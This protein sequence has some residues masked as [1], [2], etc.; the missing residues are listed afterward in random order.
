MNVT[1]PTSGLAG[2]YRP[3]VARA[4]TPATP[5]R[6]A[7]EPTAAADV[8][9]GSDPALWAILTTEERAFFQKQ[10]TMG[11]LSYSPSSRPAAST[12]GPPLGQ[13]ID[14]TA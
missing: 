1:G 4:A 9:A 8:P 11:P 12:A 10:A 6:A 7:S 3:P 5:A 13:R 14:C 2:V